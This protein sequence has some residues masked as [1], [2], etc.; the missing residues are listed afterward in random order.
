MKRRFKFKYQLFINAKT[1]RATA[2]LTDLEVD[3]PKDQYYPIREL[4]VDRIKTRYMTSAWPETHATPSAKAKPNDYFGLAL[5]KKRLFHRVMTDIID[6]L[7]CWD[8][9]MDREAMRR[10]AFIHHII[11]VDE[12]LKESIARKYDEAI[13]AEEHKDSDATETPGPVVVTQKDIEALQTKLSEIKKAL[14]EWN[15]DTASNFEAARK[16][17]RCAIESTL[18]NPLFKD[19]EGGDK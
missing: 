14:D 7:M 10:A 9:E 16:Q 18:G 8:M 17:I 4:V 1:R 2:R 11:D 12:R 15:I 3:G 19:D 5:A 13:K 6:L